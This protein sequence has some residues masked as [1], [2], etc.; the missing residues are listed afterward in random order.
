MGGNVEV[1]RLILILTSICLLVLAGCVEWSEDS[2]GNLRSIGLPGAPI[3]QSSAPPPMLTPT[4]AGMT[5]AEAAKM[6]GPV[7]VIPP[8]PPYQQW[9]YRYYRTANNHCQDDLKQMLESPEWRNA[10]GQ[11][12]YCTNRPSAPPMKRSAFIF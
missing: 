9:R 2:Q 8:N 3:W 10:T 6:G 7:M 11:K 1:R 5:P 12:P 4:E